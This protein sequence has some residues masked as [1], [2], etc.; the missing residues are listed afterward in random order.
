M[1]RMVRR[2]QNPAWKCWVITI[3]V[4]PFCLAALG[5]VVL[6][7]TAVARLLLPVVEDA[8]TPSWVSTAVTVVT[9]ITTGLAVTAQVIGSLLAGRWIYRSY[10]WKMVP[11]D[12]S[13]Y[14]KCGV[15]QT[16]NVSGICPEC[17]EKISLE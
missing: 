6:P 13:W 9:V 5:G 8:S 12:G 4:F 10:R 11:Y 17:G 1:P 7:V 3:A 2:Q 14:L 15:S 16:G